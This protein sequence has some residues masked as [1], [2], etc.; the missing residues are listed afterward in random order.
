[1]SFVTGEQQNADQIPAVLVVTAPASRKQETITQLLDVT[2]TILL[3]IPESRSMGASLAEQR[4]H[5][6]MAGPTHISLALNF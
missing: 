4:Q 3:A 6:V 1:M 5:E 2:H